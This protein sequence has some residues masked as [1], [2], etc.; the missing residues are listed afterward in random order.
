MKW[1]A[2]QARTLATSECGR[3]QV[4]RSTDPHRGE[5]YNAW[6]LPDNK[7]I[8]AS[9]Q[10]QYVIDACIAHAAKVTP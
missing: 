9:H 5:F 8:E 2:N 4:K 10:K 3:Y 1:R 7:H 6:Y